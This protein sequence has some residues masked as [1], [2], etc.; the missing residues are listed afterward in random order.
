MLSK[1]NKTTTALAVFSAVILGAAGVAT[2]VPYNPTTDVTSLADNAVSTMGPIVVALAGAVIGL[3]IL[4]WGLRAVF[5]MV[6]SGGRH[7]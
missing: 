7:L 5:R 2:A 4:A 1:L 3:A 6:G